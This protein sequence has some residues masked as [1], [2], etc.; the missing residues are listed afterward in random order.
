MWLVDLDLDLDSMEK[1]RG[2]G[3][4]EGGECAIKTY[5]STWVDLFTRWHCILKRA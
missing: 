3:K 1:G 4:G 5:G 2:G